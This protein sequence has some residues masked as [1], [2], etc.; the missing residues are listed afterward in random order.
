[1][2]ETDYNKIFEN[3]TTPWFYSNPLLFKVF[4]IHKLKPNPQIPMPFRTG[5]RL[6]EY[7]PHLLEEN[8]LEFLRAELQLELERILLQHPYR[9]PKNDET[10][11][12]VLWYKASTMTITQAEVPNYGLEN[13]RN[14]EYYYEML[15]HVQAYNKPEKKDKDGQ[16]GNEGGG[17]STEKAQQT[18]AAGFFSD[19]GGYTEKNDFPENNGGL[20]NDEIKNEEREL[21]DNK[22]AEAG[23]E[24]WSCDDE[25][26][27]AE[28]TDMLK[29]AFMHN[30]L[31][32]F[33]W[34]N[35]VGNINEQLEI[36]FLKKQKIPSYIHLLEYFK[37]MRGKNDSYL[38]RMRPSRRFCYTQMGRK[39]RPVPGKILVG[40]DV[41]SSISNDDVRRFYKSLSD[42]FAREI[43]HLE[44]FQ[45]DSGLKTE[46]PEPFKKRIQI[47]RLG[48][49]GTSFQPIFDYVIKHQNEYD[50]LIVLTDGIAHPP[51]IKKKFNLKVL[52]VLESEENY[53]WVSPPLKKS[54]LVTV[55][56]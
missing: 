32:S 7:N 26:A 39:S 46:K 44:V 25:V 4:C 1:M 5:R 34:G 37:S 49:G 53:Q 30:Q 36:F 29:D 43:K 9:H 24:L 28:M 38:T 55:L 33:R 50:G 17:G 8:T 16:L 22:N 31:H 3:L 41:S 35:V 42:V 20:H 40:I 27:E 11:D 12:K 2:S 13:N 54:G 21:L 51:V 23:S 47:T 52:W 48:T 45:F 15:K 19:G 18:E 10:F 6:I 56:H 14:I